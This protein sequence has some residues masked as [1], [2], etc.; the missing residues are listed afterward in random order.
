MMKLHLAL[1][2]IAG[3]HFTFAQSSIQHLA[4]STH[5]VSSLQDPAPSIQNPVLSLPATIMAV[6]SGDFSDPLTF[7][8][9]TPAAGD[10]II[11]PRGIEVTISGKINFNKYADPATTI[12]IR[13]SLIIQTGQLILASGSLIYTRLEGKIEKYA[14]D[15]NGIMIGSMPVYTADAAPLYGPA[16]L[17]DG[18][19]PMSL[20]NFCVRVRNNMTILHWTTGTEHNSNSFQVQRSLNGSKW[21]VVSTIPAAG[22]SSSLRSYLYIDSTNSSPATYYRVRLINSTGNGEISHMRCGRN[23][24]IPGNVSLLNASKQYLQFWFTQEVN[25]TVTF[26]LTDPAG[27]VVYEEVLQNPIGNV[28][29]PIRHVSRGQYLTSFSND[30]GFKYNQTVKLR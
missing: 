2:L 1:C 22:M 3:I 29:I 17:P 25:S 18:P 7:G 8:G 12:D 6:K 5:Q 21:D 23:T 10:N 14:G 28:T 15:N 30:D 4:S 19:V 20:L 27:K 24:E 9:Q 16:F 11:I 13:G 26:R